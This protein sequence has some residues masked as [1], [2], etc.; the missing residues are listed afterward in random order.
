LARTV[1]EVFVP[2]LVRSILK[3]VAIGIVV[4]SAAA[5]TTTGRTVD[6]TPTDSIM[7]ALPAVTH[8]DLDKYGE[9]HKA[10]CM[11]Y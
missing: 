9:C 1:L 8:S 3:L 2:F 6:D 7:S 4:S 10:A 5:C 11:G